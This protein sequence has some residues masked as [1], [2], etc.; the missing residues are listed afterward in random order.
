MNRIASLVTK[1]PQL[2]GDYLRY[3]YRPALTLASLDFSSVLLPEP[4]VIST[5]L[6]TTLPRP[7][8]HEEIPYIEYCYNCHG[9]LMNCLCHPSLWRE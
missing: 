8:N 1:F 5:A 7:Q 9:N 4:K 3:D 2:I 6:F